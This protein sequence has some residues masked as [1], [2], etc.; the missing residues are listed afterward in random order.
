M[1]LTTLEEKLLSEMDVCKTNISQEEKDIAGKDALEFIKDKFLDEWV[2][3]N[4]LFADYFFYTVKDMKNRA[5]SDTWTVKN[6][7]E[8]FLPYFRRDVEK[9]LFM[10]KLF[11]EKSHHK[12]WAIT[13]FYDNQTHEVSVG[14]SYAT[15]HSGYLFNTSEEELKEL[16][17]YLSIRF[18]VV[19]KQPSAFIR[20]ESTITSKELDEKINDYKNSLSKK[21]L[22]TSGKMAI[23]LIRNKFLKDWEKKDRLMLDY[24]NYVL[25][26]MEEWD[27]PEIWMV[28]DFFNDFKDYFAYD[29]VKGVELNPGGQVCFIF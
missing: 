8:I 27:A 16:A 11:R 17:H 13:I 6:F 19:N 3:N 28:E 23:D 26:D 24:F 5:L 22:E 1:F 25:K 4:L 10:D 21:E 12:N 15:R 2:K 18:E 20:S 7:F 9:G 29:V 14:S